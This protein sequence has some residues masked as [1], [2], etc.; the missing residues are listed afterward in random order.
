MK[1]VC[2]MLS[3]V[4]LS[5]S[6]QVEAT[7]IACFLINRYPSTT[8]NKITPQEIWPSTL[9]NYFDLKIFG[10]LAYAHVDNRKLE[11][12]CIKCVFLNYKYGVKG[13][14]LWCP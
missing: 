6:F 8:I 4:S 1:K 5:K 7:S 14:K 10:C 3:T 2:C 9:A 12:R 13:Y 11:P